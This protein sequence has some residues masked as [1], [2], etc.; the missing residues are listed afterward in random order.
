MPSD[1]E[2][3]LQRGEEQAAA[4]FAAG[5]MREYTS[6]VDARQTKELQ[7]AKL[8]QKAARAEEEAAEE[9][10]MMELVA[11]AE[12]VR[13]E[14]RRAAKEEQEAKEKADKERRARRYPR[15]N[16]RIKATP[17]PSSPTA[18]TEPGLST[19]SPAAEIPEEDGASVAT[20]PF[21]SPY[22]V[23][24]TA[25][26]Q[27]LGS[28]GSASSGDR[29]LAPNKALQNSATG[30]AISSL[31]TRIGSDRGSSPSCSSQRGEMID[32]EILEAGMSPDPS[33]LGKTTMARKG[34]AEQALARKLAKGGAQMRSQMEV[35]LSLCRVRDWQA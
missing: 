34:P 1:L 6:E 4:M 11:E 18:S 22:G 27:R 26:R 23:G 25:V 32:E 16:G 8:V 12:H 24:A 14:Q 20:S 5:C 29:A 10:R 31:A 33:P 30:K 28:A 3:Q 2:M 19:W 13:K 7:A 9:A 21:T 15:N 17:L 35:E